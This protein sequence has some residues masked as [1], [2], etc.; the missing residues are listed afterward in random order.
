MP[1]SS[2]SIHIPDPSDA[3]FGRGPQCRSAQSPHHPP[4]SP[5]NSTYS[6][7]HTNFYARTR[8]TARHT[9]PLGTTNSLRNTTTIS[10]ESLPFAI[11]NTTSPG[12]YA[13]LYFM[14]CH[15]HLTRPSLLFVGEPRRKSYLGRER[16]HA[17]TRGAS[18]TP[19]RMMRFI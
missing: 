8:T 11:L 13:A 3:I 9:M 7:H 2:D 14:S 17:A 1:D 6:R 16:T 10:S 12:M 19:T 18:I 4:P 15:W 5:Q